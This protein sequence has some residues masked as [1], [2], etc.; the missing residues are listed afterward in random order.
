M[1]ERLPIPLEEIAVFCQRYR[2]KRLSLFGSRARGDWGPE[3][4]VDLL[5]EFE[6]GTRVGFLTLARMARELSQLMGRPVDLVP[7]SGLKPA[8]REAVEG[9]EQ[10]IYAA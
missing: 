5:V 10:V 8:I 2:V 4:D 1:E 3:S 9:E 6:P 7:R